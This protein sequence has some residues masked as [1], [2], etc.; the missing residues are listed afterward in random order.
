MAFAINEESETLVEMLFLLFTLYLVLYCPALLVVVGA[1]VKPHTM[2]FSTTSISPRLLMV[3]VMGTVVVVLVPTS[4]LS[5]RGLLTT[6][7]VLVTL[8]VL[9]ASSVTVY[10][11]ACSPAFMALV[12]VMPSSIT[13]WSYRPS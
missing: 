11:T 4:V 10:V 6:V 1:L 8:E 9:P 2:P 5:E 3:P 12:T 13:L 7:I